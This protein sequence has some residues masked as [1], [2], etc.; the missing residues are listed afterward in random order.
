L[1]LKTNIQEV[2]NNPQYK[3]QKNRA[4]STGKIGD[5]EKNKKGF[6]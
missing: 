6:L 2:P 1:A 5:K 4:Y 3:T